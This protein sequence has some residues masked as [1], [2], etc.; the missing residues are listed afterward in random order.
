MR[1][2]ANVDTLAYEV[3]LGFCVFEGKVDYSD[4]VYRTCAPRTPLP[5]GITLT[6]GMT[7]SQSWINENRR[8]ETKPFAFSTA[9]SF[10][11]AGTY[12]VFAYGLS[13]YVS[14]EWSSG[15]TVHTV[16][17]TPHVITVR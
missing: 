7:R 9:V 14:R 1:S 17:R 4:E 5:S 13:W 6:S 16:E 15:E 11:S 2:S 8:G 12:T 3:E 10:A